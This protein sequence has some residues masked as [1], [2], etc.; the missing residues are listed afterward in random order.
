MGDAIQ[1]EPNTPTTA[2]PAN[3]NSRL[4]GLIQERPLASFFV[5]AYAISWILWLPLVDLR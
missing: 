1:N 2:A 5:L 4:A 3:A